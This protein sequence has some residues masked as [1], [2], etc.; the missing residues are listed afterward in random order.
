MYA[1][2]CRGGKKKRK[3][4]NPPREFSLTNPGRKFNGSARLRVEFGVAARVSPYFP[5]IALASHAL[6]SRVKCRN[7]E[8][9]SPV[10]GVKIL[11]SGNEESVNVIEKLRTD[12]LPF[13]RTLDNLWNAAAVTYRSLSRESNAERTL[14]RLSADRGR[15]LAR[16]DTKRRHDRALS[17]FS[18]ACPERQ[19]QRETSVNSSHGLEKPVRAFVSSRSQT[20][21]KNLPA[22]LQSLFCDEPFCTLQYHN[23]C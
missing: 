1:A 18:P 6:A 14:S 16:V 11:S 9:K 8:S 10:R 7:F 21:T 17:I 23:E 13:L 15:I 4:K 22:C 20:L 2:F 19:A 3:K 5:I 12:S